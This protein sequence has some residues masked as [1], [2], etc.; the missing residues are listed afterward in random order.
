MHS[1]YHASFTG[2]SAAG[3][4]IVAERCAAFLGCPR[5]AMEKMHTAADDDDDFVGSMWRHNAAAHRWQGLLRLPVYAAHVLLVCLP[6]LRDARN[7]SQPARPAPLA[8]TLLT[9]DHKPA[10]PKPRVGIVGAESNTVAYLSVE[11]LCVC[12]GR[13]RQGCAGLLCAR[14]AMRSAAMCGI[15]RCSQM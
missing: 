5:C 6:R 14:A 8:G 7:A 10:P 13:W 3:S 12:R 4:D 2:V 9:S 1:G 15:R 11:L